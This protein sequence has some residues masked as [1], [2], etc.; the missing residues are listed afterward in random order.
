[1][2]ACDAGGALPPRRH[3]TQLGSPREGAMQPVA[4]VAIIAQSHDAAGVASAT[5]TRRG[6]AIGARGP[7]WGWGRHS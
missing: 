4:C 3:R 2:E 6:G 7:N 1:M 5:Q